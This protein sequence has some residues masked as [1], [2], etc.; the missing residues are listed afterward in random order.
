MLVTYQPPMMDLN[1]DTPPELAPVF[2]FL[3]NHATK[4]YQEGYFLKLHDLDSRKKTFPPYRYPRF[5]LC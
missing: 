4:L 1:G 5:G 3:N 2:T